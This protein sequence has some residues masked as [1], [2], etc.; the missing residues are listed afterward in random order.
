MRSVNIQECTLSSRPLG[1]ARILGG[2]TR[3]FSGHDSSHLRRKR[4]HYSSLDVDSEKLF[5]MGDD[6]TYIEGIFRS[7]GS[8]RQRL[9]VVVEDVEELFD[10]AVSARKLAVDSDR[11]IPRSHEARLRGHEKDDARFIQYL[12]G[13][14]PGS[15][16]FAARKELFASVWDDHRTLEATMRGVGITGVRL[17]AFAV[18]SMRFAVSWSSLLQP[19]SLL[20]LLPNFRRM[21]SLRRRFEK[22]TRTDVRATQA[23]EVDASVECLEQLAPDLKELSR[24][25]IHHF[26]DSGSQTFFKQIN[27][28]T[29]RHIFP[30][31]Q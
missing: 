25:G 27:E 3:E 18:E 22:S 21:T 17:D 12:D 28:V 30:S 9:R 13:I 24:E 5:R 19:W 6:Y 10:R 4:R 23:R 14:M 7:L 2:D 29:D 1:D 11:T 31:M 15:R 16:L 20:H 8:H 26:A